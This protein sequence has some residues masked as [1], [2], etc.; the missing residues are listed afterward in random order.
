MRKK[1]I[2]TE[3]Q[4]HLILE[5]GFML[6]A[7]NKYVGNLLTNGLKST[8]QSLK[9][10]KVDGDK[11]TITNLSNPSERNIEGV[12]DLSSDRSGKTYKRTDGKGYFTFVSKKLNEQL[13]NA[14]VTNKP[15]Y[16]IPNFMTM[17][18][19]VELVQRALIK[20]GYSVGV[21]GADGILG[22]NTKNAIIKYQKDNGIK[23]TGI[24]GP[25]TAKSLGVQSLTSG[26]PLATTP[27][28]T[29]K[30]PINLNPKAPSQK[31]KI[32]T[33]L[34]TSKVDT[35]SPI[36]AQSDI[37]RQIAQQEL[38]MREFITKFPPAKKSSLP[39]HIRALMDY[40]S[41]RETT[42][43]AVD[44]TR[45]EQNFL[46]K[47]ATSNAKKGLT[48]PLWKDIGAGNLPTSMT[49]SGSEKEKE[50]LKSKDGEGS[51]LKPELAGQFMYTLGEISPPNIKVD[52]TKKT[53]TV[54]DRY[55]FNSQGK[56]KEDLIKSFADQLG[57][58][59]KGDSTFYSVVRNVVAFKESGGYK[60]FPVNITV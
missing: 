49:V 15:T 1:I 13:A 44:L 24:V 6:G 21:K 45:D 18:N 42:F 7:G 57:S 58:W 32:D 23:Q 60:G 51:L 19:G 33:S 48:Y 26:K 35:N 50:K 56:T 11:V 2:I 3:A 8:G 29:K 39:L 30:L 16:E 40:L 28:T 54:F 25:I 53:V 27:T 14:R 43:T 41:G 36:V 17:P 10:D 47:V 38:K 5:Q 55:D 37:N 59:W 52:P 9:I 12:K 31:S 22:P 20:K 34:G 4:F 46:K